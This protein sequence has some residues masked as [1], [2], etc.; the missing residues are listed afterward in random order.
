MKKIFSILLLLLFV[1]ASQC[2]QAQGWKNPMTL[3]GL[4]NRS[5]GDPYIMKYRGYYYLYVSAG[6]RNIYCWRSKD[7]MEWSSSY[8]CCTDETTAVAYAPEVIYWNGKFYMCTSPRGGG[9][10]MLTSDS[11]MG[12]FVHRTGNLGR[13]IDGSMFVDDDGSWYFYHA[14]NGGIRGCTMPTHLSYGNDVDL[15]CC[16]SGQWTEGPCMFKRNGLY[17]LLYTGNHVWTNGYRIDYAVS[18]GGPLTG[19]RP[20]SDQNPI[21]IDTE[22]PTHKA[23]GHGTAF[24]GPDLDT[25]FFCYH[26]LQDNKARRLLNFERIAWNGDKLMMTGPTDWE[27]DKPLVATNDYF[28]RTAIG[29]SWTIAD[30]GG[31]WA[32]AEEDHLCQTATEGTH[33]AIFNP[34]SYGSYTAEFTLKAVEGEGSCGALFSRQD[35][36]NYCEA[37]INVA[38]KTFVVSTY[39]EGTLQSTESYSLPADFDPACWHSIRVEKNGTTARVYI[40][41]MRKAQLTISESAGQIGYVTLSCAAD[42]GYI[43]ISPYVDGSGILDVSLPVPGIIASNLCVE[44]NDEVTPASMTF[45]SV[46]TTMYMKCETGS[47]LK[48]NVNIQRDNVYNIGLRYR[49]TKVMHFRVLI[50]G[51]PVAD[52]VELPIARSARVF[53][54]KDVPMPAGRHQLTFEA[55]DGAMYIYEY[56]IK[57]GVKNPHVMSD[58]FENGFSSEWGYKE[59]NWSI[60]DGKLESTG[61]Y[62][63]MLMGGYDDIHLTDY[64]VECDISYPNGQMNAGLLIRATNAST[65]GA[66]DN[67]V[68]GT[69]FLQ[70]YFF[71]AGSTSVALGKQNYSWQTLASASKTVSTDE[72]H[73]MKVEVEG[74]NIRC[75]LDDM[76]KPLINYTDTKPFITGRAGLRAHDSSVRFDNFVVTPMVK[77]ETGIA[78]VLYEGSASV[79]AAPRYYNLNGQMLSP[80]DNLPHGIYIVRSKSGTSKI[81]R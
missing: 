7:L 37:L 46:G 31:S 1:C 47:V 23:L 58:D 38:E 67:P 44:K 62:G 74:S 5:L 53:T 54:I 71:L 80:G 68:L 51:E 73:H 59:G 77:E 79:S 22:T 48:Y 26:N 45:S 52:N 28:E 72:T 75:Y 6:D 81:V 63:K 12:P 18:N 40:D 64:T 25:Y 36:E 70:G 41:G 43:A 13:D 10:Y 27:Q 34:C 29:P 66:D 78:P 20:Q 30:D 2:V 32:I 19:F 76:E 9:H 14:N 42:F 33:T 65:G 35:A 49:A 50:D 3:P 69:D 55:V 60:V 21:L 16:M 39:T 61:K 56:N 15:G 24:V 4:E 11:P 57:R 17:Y 8:I